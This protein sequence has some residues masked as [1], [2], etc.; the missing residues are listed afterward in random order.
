M[1]VVVLNFHYC[2]PLNKRDLPDW[3]RRIVKRQTIF[4]DFDCELRHPYTTG[5]IDRT[6]VVRTQPDGVTNDNQQQFMEN[7][8]LPTSTMVDGE[9]LEQNSTDKPNLYK[10][11]FDASY[12]Q[13]NVFN[14]YYPDRSY[15]QTINFT[16]SSF[17]PSTRINT[18][19]LKVS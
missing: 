11:M 12:N 16:N 17:N 14:G 5:G 6:R 8:V 2:S 4:D 19:A 9:F 10:S 7:T 18:S 15:E 1:T 3:L 13:Q